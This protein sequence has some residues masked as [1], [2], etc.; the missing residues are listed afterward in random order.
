MSRFLMTGMEEVS[1]VV[2]VGV[3]HYR[4]KGTAT[5]TQGNYTKSPQERYGMGTCNPSYTPG[6]GS[7]LSLNQPEEKL[8]NKEDKQCF[9]TIMAS[10]MYLDRVTRYDILYPVHQL[11]RAI[12]KAHMAAANT[13]FAT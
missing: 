7:E 9:Q 11:A 10:V 12:T 8:L 4:E 2:V 6:V 1:L 5:I 13:Y 3:T